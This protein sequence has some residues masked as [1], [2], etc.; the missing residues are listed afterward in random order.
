[1]PDFFSFV[2]FLFALTGVYCLW[3]ASRYRWLLWPVLL[4]FFFRTSLFVLD[5][6]KTFRPPGAGADASVFVNRASRFAKME[7]QYLIENVPLFNSSF[8]PWLGG[9]IQKF[10]G[11]S[12]YFLLATSFFFGHVV[13]VVTG[14]ICYQLWG[15]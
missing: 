7:W 15:R 12:E 8:Y 10:V 11:E 4:A 14:I 13:V 5:Y 9:L 1:M 2:F 3:I 6:T